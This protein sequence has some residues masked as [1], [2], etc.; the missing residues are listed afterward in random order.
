MLDKETCYGLAHV[1]GVLTRAA[2][3]YTVFG[4]CAH[5]HQS[6]F[7]LLVYSSAD[8]YPRFVISALSSQRLRCLQY[9]RHFMRKGYLSRMSKERPYQ[10]GIRTVWSSRKYAYMVLN[11]FNPTFIQENWGLQGYTLVFLFCSKT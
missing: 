10:P 2:A 8:W 4:T 9:L 5:C 11:P 3:C 7:Y 1:E 6:L